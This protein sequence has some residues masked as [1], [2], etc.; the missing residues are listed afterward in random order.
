MLYLT[1]GSP[2]HLLGTLKGSLLLQKIGE[3]LDRGEV[4]AG[5]SAGAMVMG[6]WMRFRGWSEGLGI[7][8]G[9]V[10]LP[11]HESSD[12]EAVARQTSA[13]APS[14]VTLV[15]IDGRTCC[16]RGDDGWKV[17]GVGGVTAYREGRWRRFASGKA[18]PADPD[19][20]C[21]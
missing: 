13:S 12:P 14:G 9:V 20:W 17:L 2:T 1:G 6:P 8:P 21:A 10:V 16:V 18:M 5:S 15:G 19:E 4:L 11:H 7:V 3:A